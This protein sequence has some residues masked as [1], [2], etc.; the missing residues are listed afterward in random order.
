[1]TSLLDKQTATGPVRPIAPPQGQ[2]VSRKDV[3][4]TARIT[5]LKDDGLIDRAIKIGTEYCEQMIAGHRQFLTASYAVGVS[6]WWCGQLKIPR[7]PLQT[8]DA[9]YYYDTDGNQQTLDESSYTVTVPWR[10]QGTVTLLASAALPDVQCDIPY[11]I[12]I[13]FTCGYGDASEVP[14]GIKYAIVVA[15]SQIYYGRRTINQ[16][17][18]ES[19][20]LF[21]ENTQGY[22]SYA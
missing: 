16:E 17:T 22:G 4:D 20:E 2:V 19:I 10:S 5:S 12:E 15:A 8:V 18:A 9:I 21:L 3:K 1:M 6:D 13:H 11:P 7:P 14:E